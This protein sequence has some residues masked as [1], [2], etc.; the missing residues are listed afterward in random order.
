MNNIMKKLYEYENSIPRYFN[1]DNCRL[2][3]LN[4]YNLMA[5]NG[6]LENDVV[7]LLNDELYEEELK[8]NGYLTQD[9]AI[10]LKMLCACGMKKWSG[11]R[12]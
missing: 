3:S 2:T 6:E 5:Y 1:V 11:D 7:Y 10:R 9:E 8:K 12:L 4:N